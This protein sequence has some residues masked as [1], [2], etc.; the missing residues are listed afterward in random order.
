MRYLD[1]IVYCIYQM[2]PVGWGEDPL[3]RTMVIRGVVSV[4]SN[5]SAVKCEGDSYGKDIINRIAEGFG[6]INVSRVVPVLGRERAIRARA[7]P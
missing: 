3:L 1:P 6:N 4:G 2:F 7:A 5:N